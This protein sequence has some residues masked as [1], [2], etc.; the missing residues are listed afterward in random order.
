MA[1]STADIAAALPEYDVVKELGRGAMGIVYLGRHRRLERD[2][3]IK[4]LPR[5]F[6]VDPEV[7]RRFGVEAQ[8]LASLNH[9]HVVPVYDYVEVDGLC[10][11]VMESL[12]GGTVWDR[13][14]KQ[15][16]TIPQACATMLATCSA[17]EHAH[18]KGILHRDIKP[19][20]LMF[21]EDDSVKVTDFGIAKVLSGSRTMA[22]AD[23]SVLGTP[24]YMAPEQA[25][26]KELT[27]QVDV[28]AAG[29]ML[30]EMLSGQLPF[31][32]DELMAMLLA[33]VNED[34]P[35]LRKAAPSV[36]EPLAEVAMRAVARSTGDR[37][38]SAEEF[39]VALGMA[40]ATSWGAEWLGASGLPVQGSETIA[41]AAR[42][43]IAPALHQAN[44]A[45]GTVIQPP[46]TP[47]TSGGEGLGPSGTVLQPTPPTGPDQDE[48]Q[49]EGEVETPHVQQTSAQPPL[50][51]PVTV[52]RPQVTT[53]QAG[54]DAAALQ[55]DSLPQ[56]AL[57]NVAEVTKPPATPIASILAGLAL[58][59]LGLVVA[60]TGIGEPSI[61]RS[62]PAGEINGQSVVSAS[63]IELDLD[64][65]IVVTN[66]FGDAA[67]LQFSLL[68]IPVSATEQAPIVSGT[69][70]LDPGIA[71]RIVSGSVTAE[72]RIFDTAGNQ[73]AGTEVAI[74]ATNP[75]FTS[76]MGVLGVVLLL[77]AFAAVESN[78][79]PMR[80]GRRRL[81][82]LLGLLV[83]GAVAGAG[84]ALTAAAM[85]ATP[86]T[87]TGIVVAGGLCAG[88]AVVFGLA[89]AR[90]GRRRRA[91]RRA[92]ARAAT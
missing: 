84:A 52:V 78:L 22:T 36:P 57:V 4:E 59:L 1:R 20:N 80:K 25:E 3:A 79:R 7:R 56:G 2:V 35:D 51:A 44:P 60:V 21:A 63:A 32:R 50:P 88:G 38:R 34:P 86:L 62:L 58:F 46:V 31:Q 8:V 27:P 82:S 81:G 75:W 87:M 77:F 48:P 85:L 61:E 74:E 45:P 69:A 19:E 49:P 47:D 91:Q 92:R 16:L 30:Y 41:R 83:S 37:Y 53:H 28:Y 73:V 5:A 14:T 66:L 68:G 13:F 33:R 18:S 55:A 67:D 70:D 15:G 71:P 42:T 90:S 39:G 26:G 40:A 9:P 17:L 65:N 24:A 10:L 54:L 43:T 89:T 23:G 6:A 72:L 76:A 11:L 12:P 29:T 64:Q